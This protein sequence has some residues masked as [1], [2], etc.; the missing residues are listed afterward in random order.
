MVQ[1]VNL[2]VR[3]RLWVVNALI[4]REVFLCLLSFVSKIYYGVGACF[5]ALDLFAFII[6][7]YS[8]SRSIG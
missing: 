4:I 3:S 8:S 6:D 1:G 5:L 7:P 2:Y